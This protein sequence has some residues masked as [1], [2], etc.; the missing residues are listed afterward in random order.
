MWLIVKYGKYK[1][2]EEYYWFNCL[3]EVKWLSEKINVVNWGN[4]E[5]VMWM[6][7]KNDKW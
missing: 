5:V 1:S 7:K 6:S 3:K 2:L 4:N